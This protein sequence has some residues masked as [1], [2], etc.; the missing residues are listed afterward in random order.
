MSESA[1]SVR[2]D[3]S[4]GII[5][6]S[7]PDKDWIAEQLATLMPTL[8]AERPPKKRRREDEGSGS[9]AKPEGRK[10]STRSR[11][12]SASSGKANPNLSERLSSET[13]TK[14]NDYL[15]QR[16]KK[17][18]D[19]QSQAAVIATFLLDE[20]DWPEVTAD[21][22]FTV[23]SD[24]GL[25]IPATR[26]ALSNAQ[27]RKGYFSTPSDGKYRISHRGQNFARHDSKA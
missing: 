23:Y 10:P 13:K 20:L 12:A 1:Y 4:Q 5:D 9:P 16:S 17:A 7:G 3:R 6:I 27:K 19:A 2:V 15:E 18:S 11:R 21:D 14:L 8:E 26:S 24:M 25:K 22:L